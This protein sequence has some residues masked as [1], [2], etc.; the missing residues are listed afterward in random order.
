M[1]WY[2]RALRI[3]SLIGKLPTGERIWGGPYTLPQVG[4][5]GGIVV[6]G[7]VTMSW[8]GP[9]LYSG[10]FAFFVN[11]AALFASAAVGGYAVRYLPSSTISPLLLV[12]GSARLACRPRTR[13]PRW[14]GRVLA[15]GGPYRVRARWLSAERGLLPSAGD[16][17]EAP[18]TAAD[19]VE[20]DVWSGPAVGGVG[21]DV[22][23]ECP[24]VAQAG[25]VDSP[26]KKLA[27]LLARSAR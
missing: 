20:P 14:A 4:V 8:W 17:Q 18:P 25:G 27:G 22:A 1:R 12:A 3:P 10:A 26:G 9:L 16:R 11:W 6:V 7:A 5:A 13:A 21:C 15:P 2:T 19:P 23:P 24:P